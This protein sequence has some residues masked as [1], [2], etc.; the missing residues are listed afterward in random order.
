M[1]LLFQHLLQ[2]C[3]RHRYSFLCNYNSRVYRSLAPASAATRTM[4]WI[5]DVFDSWCIL[6]HFMYP[7]TALYQLYQ[8]FWLRHSMQTT[9]RIQAYSYNQAHSSRDSDT[10]SC[11]SMY[12]SIYCPPLLWTA[13]VVSRLCSFLLDLP[14]RCNSKGPQSVT[15]ASAASSSSIPT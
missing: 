1:L 11:I 2:P 7:L 15:V 13:A 5:H 6:T 9:R 12:C 4:A 10:D 14:H 8:L 3:R